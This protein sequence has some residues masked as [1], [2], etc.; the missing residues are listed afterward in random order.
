MKRTW[1]GTSGGALTD[2]ALRELAIDR[3]TYHKLPI[4]TGNP[5]RAALDAIAEIL[6]LAQMPG[7]EVEFRQP[8]LIPEALG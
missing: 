1:I 5:A 4:T 8:G 7:N 2:V 6:D 3:Y